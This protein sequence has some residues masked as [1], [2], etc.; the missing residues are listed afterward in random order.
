MPQFA[1]WMEACEQ[2]DTSANVLVSTQCLRCAPW[3]SGIRADDPLPFERP[4][5]KATPDV[6]LCHFVSRF[7]SSPVVNILFLLFA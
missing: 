3:F 1:G 4:N 5:T 7:H 6:C 2:A